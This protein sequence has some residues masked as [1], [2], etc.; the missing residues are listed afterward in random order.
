MLV[1]ISSWLIIAVMLVVAYRSIYNTGAAFALVLCMY[2]SEQVLLQGKTGLPIAGA[3]INFFVGGIVLLSVGNAILQNRFADF[4]LPQ[5][6]FYAY[7]I[8]VIAALSFLW[9][10]DQREAGRILKEAIPYLAIIVFAAPFCLRSNSNCECFL[11]WFIIL[12]AAVC[13]GL[14]GSSVIHRSIHI[15]VGAGRLQR[16][17]P[18]AAGS[19][20]GYTLI[21]CLYC[22]YRYPYERFRTIGLLLITFLSVYALAQSGSRGQIV[23]FGLTAMVWVPILAQIRGRGS[24]VTAYMLL[25]AL[26]VAGYL[27][28][29]KMGLLFRFSSEKVAVGV[30]HR[31]GPAT[32]M[33]ER[34]ENS[35]IVTWIFGLG[36]SASYR[37]IGGYPH[38]VPIEV[39]TEEGL[40]GAIVYA[41]FVVSTI[42]VLWQKSRDPNDPLRREA[43]LFGALFFFEFLLSLKQGSLIGNQQFFCFGI[44]SLIYFSNAL[45]SRASLPFQPIAKPVPLRTITS[46]Q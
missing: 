22:L 29:E 43:C 25:V 35:D 5:R 41:T 8:L 38:N 18:L 26:G 32:V 19:F 14:A 13:I 45:G 23:A 6:I 17:N 1:T 27:F 39:L 4:Q 24:Y 9:T 46:R 15:E 12:G 36:T 40:L 3:A 34:F 2:A 30:N 21:C 44:A 33:L 10:P 31:L 20:A 7:G 11:K 37:Y 42:L 28:L 16:M